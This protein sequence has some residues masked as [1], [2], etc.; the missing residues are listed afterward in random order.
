MYDRY[1]TKNFQ[2]T[3]DKKWNMRRMSNSMLYHS[4]IFKCIGKTVAIKKALR[5]RT[6]PLY[7]TQAET[8]RAKRG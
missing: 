7:F 5:C 3:L 2:N 6:E 4:L 8:A 1:L